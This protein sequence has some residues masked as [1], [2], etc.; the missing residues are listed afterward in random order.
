MTEKEWAVVAE[1][2]N[3]SQAQL[4]A[5]LLEECAIECLVWS[6]DCGGIAP[7][8]SF[9]RGVKVYVAE[10]DVDRA[11]EILRRKPDDG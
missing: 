10:E 11:L 2:G 5:N 3:H 1:Y 8:Q 4:A 9:V 6:D 7:G